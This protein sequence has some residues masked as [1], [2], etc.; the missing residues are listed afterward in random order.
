MHIKQKA[1]NDTFFSALL[2]LVHMSI[3][4]LKLVPIP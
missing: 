4:I 3:R 1:H 2:V